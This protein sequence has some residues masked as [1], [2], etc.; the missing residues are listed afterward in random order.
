MASALPI[1]FAQQHGVTTARHAAPAS[2]HKLTIAVGGEFTSMDP[3]YFNFGPN[4]ALAFYVFEPLIRFDAEFHP[5]PALA[6]A[7]AALDE[8]T[9]EIKLRPGVRFHD[10]A[11]FTADDVVFSFACIPRLLLSPGSFVYAV[12]PILQTEVVDH[13]TL[14]LH[15]AAPVLL[16]PYNL[17]NGAAGHAGPADHSAASPGQRWAVRA[18]LM[19]RAGLTFHARM[20]ERTDARD[21]EPQ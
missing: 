7:W 6:V 8:Q 14:R 21:T 5:E 17:T 11:P 12:K 15:T 10:G 16:M 4:N 9:R 13:Y 1:A 18:G 2:P 20:Q 19:F 3:H